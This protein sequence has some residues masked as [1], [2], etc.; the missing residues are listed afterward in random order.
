LSYFSLLKSKGAR[1][2]I[3]RRFFSPDECAAIKAHGLSTG[4]PWESI[5]FEKKG[6]SENRDQKTFHDDINNLTALP[7]S[8]RELTLFFLRIHPNTRYMAFKLLKS[9]SPC[10]QQ[11]IHAD[12]LI[13]STR[14]A[15]Q[16]IP[17]NIKNSFD[18]LSFSIIIT[19]EPDDNRTAISLTN[20]SNNDGQPTTPL[21]IFDE[22]LTQG[23]LIILRGDT[24]HAGAAYNVPNSE[25][26]RCFIGIGTTIYPND[27]LEVALI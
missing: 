12:D 2:C 8:L 6:K 13:L 14:D 10:P 21:E 27:G 9:I 15:N 3:V 23:S 22:T 18:N 11:S 19:L 17:A 24:L 20:W 7:P 25:N 16:D 4:T 26:I 1:Y 5:N